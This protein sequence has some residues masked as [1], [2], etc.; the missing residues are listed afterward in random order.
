MQERR[1]ELVQSSMFNGEE[2]QQELIVEEL[3]NRG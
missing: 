1:G 2:K 3:L